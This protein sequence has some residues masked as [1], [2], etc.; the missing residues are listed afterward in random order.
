[1]LLLIW[2]L[3]VFALRASATQCPHRPFGRL[4]ENIARTCPV[5]GRIGIIEDKNNVISW[6]YQPKCFR[7]ENETQ[8]N[9]LFTSTN[10]RNGHGISLVTSTTVASHLVGLGAFEDSPRRHS[11][12]A[13]DIVP[14]EGKGLGVVATR[15]IRRGEIIIVDMPAVLIGISFLTTT[16][17]HHRRRIIKQAF[18]QLRAETKN[19]IYGLHQAGS[20]YQVDAI[21]G[22]NAH[23]VML[24]DEVHVG[25]FTQL[26]VRFPYNVLRFCSNSLQRINH[27]CRP[28]Y[29]SHHTRI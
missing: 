19:Q 8:I 3:L 9:C 21:L 14:M 5:P 6:E 11:Q 24:A 17:P 28:K 25:L 10:F 29:V 18:N 22:P 23:T 15:K 27:A 16:K 4:Q 12:P 20:P 2:I 1:M 13:Y 26:A 7:Q